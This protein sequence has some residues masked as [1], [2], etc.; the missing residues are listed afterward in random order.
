[1]LHGSDLQRY[2]ILDPNGP[3][4]MTGYA[5]KLLIKFACNAFSGAQWRFKSEKAK[6]AMKIN[7]SIWRYIMFTRFLCSMSMALWFAAI[8]C[9]QETPAGHWEGSFTEGNRQ[10]GLSLNL[11]KNAQS[12]WI[13]SMGFPSE[14]RTGLVVMDLAV[15]D[16][17]VN[18][19]A[20]EFMM[21]KVN[22]ALGLDG[23][24]KGMIASAQGALP[25]E[26]TR[27]GEA[28]VELIPA[29]PAVA[30]SLEGD[31]EGSLQVP[32]RAFQIIIHFKN[33]ADNT[34]LAT[35]DTPDSGAMGLP[36][37]NVKQ[38]GQQVE[39]GIKVAHA[40]FQGT[41]NVEGTELVG[42][43]GHEQN[44]AALTLHKR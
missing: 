6:I 33:Q 25:I 12:E 17:S 28:K 7:N 41:L 11:A 37:N 5:K 42:Q 10:I 34:V 15:N 44:S 18:F 19:V 16:K 30:K 22:L 36:L 43:F 13:A 38:N 3:I 29:S 31:W 40:E 20:V 4:M 21:A 26:F 39:F 1:M 35:I 9:A 14:K 32:N 8:L 23:K 2:G 24:M 27:T